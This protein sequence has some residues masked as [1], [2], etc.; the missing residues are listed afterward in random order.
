MSEIEQLR[1]EL[2]DYKNAYQIL[3]KI[4]LKKETL[5]ICSDLDKVAAMKEVHEKLSQFN[6]ERNE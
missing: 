4:L 6:R 3:A 5:V 2:Q 1:Q